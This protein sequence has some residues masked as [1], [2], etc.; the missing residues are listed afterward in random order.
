MVKR[1]REA[2]R[3]L[4]VFDSGAVVQTEPT[5][6]MRIAVIITTY[7]SEDAFN[8]VSETTNSIFEEL[9]LGPSANASPT[10]FQSWGRPIQCGASDSRALDASLP[11]RERRHLATDNAERIPKGNAST[12]TRR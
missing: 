2:T 1:M 9:D 4:D 12:S 3:D 10:K 8:A 6:G 11:H 7:E 5:G